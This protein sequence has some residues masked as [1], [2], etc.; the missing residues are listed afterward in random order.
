MVPLK[1]Y[2][3]T[4]SIDNSVVDSLTVE[5]NRPPRYGTMSVTPSSGEAFTTLFT[6]TASD[7]YDDDLPLKY[8][9][10]AV[11]NGEPVPISL[12]TENMIYR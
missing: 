8:S 7:W 2:T 12:R 4:W 1:T 11:R 6:A 3:V 5:T 9:Y 10:Y